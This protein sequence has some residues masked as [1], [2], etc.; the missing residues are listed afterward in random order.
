LIDMA[1]HGSSGKCFVCHNDTV[2]FSNCDQC[3]RK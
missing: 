2:T 3:H 1:D